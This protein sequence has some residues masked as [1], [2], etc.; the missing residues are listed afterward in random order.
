MS[1]DN[2]NN[3]PVAPATPI[4]TRPCLGP[5]Q[6][7][8]GCP[9]KKNSIGTFTPAALCPGCMSGWKELHP[10]FES[11]NGGKKKKPT[12]AA[13][14][15]PAPAPTP[16]NDKP[17]DVRSW[18]NDSDDEA[19]DSEASDETSQH[20]GA[21]TAATEK[22]ICK[23]NKKTGC[24]NPRHATFPFCRDCMS[25]HKKAKKAPEQGAASA[26]PA[27]TSVPISTKVRTM[28]ATQLRERIS[29]LQQELRELET[30]RQRRIDELNG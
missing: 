18:V 2:A 7:E 21:G 17:F 20:S 28:T 10:E 27:P 30:E 8:N 1:S 14:A 11:K 3:T 5:N 22:P 24:N 12:N 15:A 16:Q 25:A 9:K 26:A 23:N 29:A 13:T 19:S 6:V 4:E